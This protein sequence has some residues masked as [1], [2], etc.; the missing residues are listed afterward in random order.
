MVAIIGLRAVDDVQCVVVCPYVNQ[1][2][3][4]CPLFSFESRS[5]WRMMLQLVPCTVSAS[6]A[7]EAS[8]VLAVWQFES[9]ANL[10][11]FGSHVRCG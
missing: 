7:M 4:A 11:L 8:G 2:A 1:G 6:C 10:A 3:C 9:F 5:N